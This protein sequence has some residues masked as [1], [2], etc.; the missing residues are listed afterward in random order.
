MS[1]IMKTTSPRP[2]ALKKKKKKARQESNI[3][4]YFYS[5]QSTWEMQEEQGGIVGIVLDAKWYEPIW[6][7]EEDID[8]A[9][10]A[11]DFELGWYHLSLLMIVFQPNFLCNR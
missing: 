9:N 7:S 4:S 10:R 11:M 2:F 3:K 8:A 6:D 1:N 5:L